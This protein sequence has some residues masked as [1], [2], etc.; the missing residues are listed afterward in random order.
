MSRENLELGDDNPAGLGR[1][2]ISRANLGVM[3]M[4]YDNFI[5]PSANTSGTEAGRV[6][7]SIGGDFNNS[8][9][10]LINHDFS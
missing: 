2:G 3:S 6:I 8:P 1:N 9:H 10:A 4:V 7:K 5:H